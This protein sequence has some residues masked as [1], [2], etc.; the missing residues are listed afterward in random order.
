MPPREGR[1]HPL[2]PDITPA[3]WARAEQQV[4]YVIAK[5]A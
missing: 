2:Y 3:E 4:V 1:V 5:K